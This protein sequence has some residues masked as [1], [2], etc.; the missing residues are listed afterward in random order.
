MVASVSNGQPPN[1]LIFFLFVDEM[2]ENHEPGWPSLTES[3]WRERQTET[4]FGQTDC[5]PAI[6]WGGA[7]RSW[8]RYQQSAR[9]VLVSGASNNG[10]RLLF[11]AILVLCVIIAGWWAAVAPILVTFVLA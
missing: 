2:H 7:L 6:R 1:L 10:G 5:R 4:C 8:S 11:G 3:L 9:L